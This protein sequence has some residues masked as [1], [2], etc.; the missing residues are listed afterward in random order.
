MFRKVLIFFIN[1]LV[2]LLTLFPLL[3]T[4]S[5]LLH[6]FNVSYYAIDKVGLTIAIFYTMIYHR[7]RDKVLEQWKQTIDEGK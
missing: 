6:Y 2:L 7:L 1:I 3:Y 4:V 5:S